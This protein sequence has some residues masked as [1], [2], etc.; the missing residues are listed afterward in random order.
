VSDTPQTQSSYD[1]VAEEYARRIYD[2]LK[3]K[4]LD[5]D[6]LKRFAERTAGKGRVCD[7]GC[8][9][10]Q[11]ARFLHD[12]GVDASGLDLSPGMVDM[13]QHLNPSMTF[14]QGDMRALPFDDHSLAGLT[15]FYSIIHIPREDVT[16]VMRE[17][18]R[19]LQP[20]R[21]LLLAFHKGDQVIHLDEWWEKPVSVD[22][23]FFLPDEM[24]GYLRAA[25]FAVDE[26]IE[27]DPYPEVEH[28]SQRVYIF[29]SNRS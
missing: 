4:P 14:Q 2:E 12:L 16:T 10:G 19:V 6:L 23:T 3:D 22:F 9:P 5:R 11:V 1:A 25:G 15:A 7:L 20:G 21:L 27:R 17:L 18:R 13:A 8:G 28:Q 24:S 29:A 26:V